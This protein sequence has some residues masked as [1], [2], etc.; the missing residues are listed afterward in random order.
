[1]SWEESKHPRAEDGKFTDGNGRSAGTDVVAH[2]YTNWKTYN[3][4][5]H[6]RDMKMTPRE[7][8]RAAVEFF[9]GEEGKRL[10]GVSGKIYKYD[11]RTYRVSVC[12]P[13][14]EILTFFQA[15]KRWYQNKKRKGEFKE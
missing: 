8:R 13:K 3:H 12:S 1:M 15:D 7:Y 6:A 14:G 9:N 4:L 2:D 11:E 5:G 10:E